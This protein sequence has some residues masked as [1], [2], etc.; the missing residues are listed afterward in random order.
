MTK[1]S[2]F[3]DTESGYGKTTFHTAFQVN[4]QCLGIDPTP[5]RIE[6]SLDFFYEFLCNSNIFTDQDFLKEDKNNISNSLSHNLPI[7]KK[8]EKIKLFESPQGLIESI[9]LENNSYFETMINKN[10]IMDDFFAKNFESKQQGI[11]IDIYKNKFDEYFELRELEIEKSN[12]NYFEENLLLNDY[13]KMIKFIEN[14]KIIDF[15]IFKN[16]FIDFIKESSTA[17]ITCSDNLENIE[18]KNLKKKALNPKK[19]VNKKNQIKAKKLSQIENQIS[20]E[21]ITLQIKDSSNYLN[22][23]NSNKINCTSM[24]N[25][26]DIKKALV[27]TRQTYDENWWSLLSFECKCVS[28]FK[29]FINEKNEHFTHIYSSNKNIGKEGAITMAKILN[30]TNFLVLAW[31][32]T[33]F[34]SEIA[35]LEN[36]FYLCCFPM[37]FHSTEKFNIYI[38]I[39][40][41]NEN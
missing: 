37:L 13:F 39:K 6:F 9:L 16:E 30:K 15:F 8:I 19:I 3:L 12:H 35:G 2:L 33:P 11:S 20:D 4:C 7:E 27:T 29:N 25:A 21:D 34:E 31:C 23:E 40:T 38:Y 36:C 24:I 5:I 1:N 41:K 18:N 14:Y 26:L 32:L 17:K 28:N 22:K 10:F